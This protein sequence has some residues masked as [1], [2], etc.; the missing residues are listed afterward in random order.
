MVKDSTW[1]GGYCRSVQTKNTG[2]QA[3]NGWALRFSLPTSAV[4][5]QSWSGTLTR[6]G[7]AVTVNPAAWAAQLAP[8][9]TVT[10]FGFCVTT[11]SNANGAAEP[12]G[13]V[14]G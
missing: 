8:G 7:T 1:D 10:S 2:S 13:V 3:I 11:S 5:S 6:S 9:Q 4:I 14:A 12:A